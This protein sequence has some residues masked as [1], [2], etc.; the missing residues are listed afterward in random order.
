MGTYEGQHYRVGVIFQ[1]GCYRCQTFID[2]AAQKKKEGVALPKVSIIIP[3]YNGVGFI[4][5]CVESALT[6]TLQDIEII[7]VDAGS[8]DGTTDI[9]REYAARDKRIRLLHSNIKSMGYQYNLGISH[10]T[11]EYIGFLEADDCLAPAMFEMLYAAIEKY[12]VDYV[13]S[14]YDLFIDK[15]ERLFLRYPV[16]SGENRRLY[17][18]VIC[19]SDYPDILYRDFAMWNGIYKK[20][21]LESNYIVLNETPKAAFQDAGFVQQTFVMA[22]KAVYLQTDSYKYRKDNMN[23]SMYDSKS[24]IFVVQEFEY[25]SCF[26]QG[27]HVN[28]ALRAALFWRYFNLFCTFYDRLPC[29]AEWPKD[30]F[31]AVRRFVCLMKQWREDLKDVELALENSAD[32][33]SFKLFFE[34]EM[35]FEAV[36]RQLVKIKRGRFEQFWKNVIRYPQTV[37]FGAGEVGSSCY[38][39]LRKNDYLNTVCFCDNNEAL[40]GQIHMGLPVLSPEEAISNYAESLFV[41]ANEAHWRN[42][43]RQLL[44]N[45]VAETQI[46]RAEMIGQF[47]ALDLILKQKG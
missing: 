42:I 4:R 30:V 29:R 20:S 5:E 14:D 17:D 7:P 22:Q 16:L 1:N 3:V 18:R 6:Q 38:G 39:M 35:E 32:P 24:V 43:Y 25:I 46:C 45:G 34:D 19:P 27:A 36:R 37:I 13:K 23:S 33:V 2:I 47:E 21:F 11:G 31:Q 41:I 26:L 10:A 44:E 15:D 40:W 28:S 9:L 12:D 8:T